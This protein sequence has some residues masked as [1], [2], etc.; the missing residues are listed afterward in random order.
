[1]TIEQ[2]QS[3]T[4]KIE[5]EAAVAQDAFTAKRASM[6]RRYA[7][8][9]GWNSAKLSRSQFRIMNNVV[10]HDILRTKESA[11]LTR[12]MRALREHNWRI[13]R[14]RDGYPA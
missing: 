9:Q 4:L 10:D 11:E 14:V 3:L 8:D 5:I 2:L 13:V 12:A 6:E 1:M 7:E